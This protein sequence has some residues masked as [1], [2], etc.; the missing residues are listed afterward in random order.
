MIPLRFIKRT[1]LSKIN[2]IAVEPTVSACDMTSC[3]ANEYRTF[4]ERGLMAAFFLLIAILCNHVFNQPG[5]SRHITHINKL[6]QMVLK[7]TELKMFIPPF[8]NEYILERP[9]G[10]VD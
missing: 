3:Q 1:A 9:R 5:P 10:I 4:Q 2:G 6:N 8:P 7:E